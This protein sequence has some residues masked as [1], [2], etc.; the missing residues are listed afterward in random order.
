MILT[1]FTEYDAYAEAVRDVSVVMRLSRLQEPKWKLQNLVIGAVRLQ[2]GFE[3][4]G[5]IAEGATVDDG[6][7]FFHQ[8]LPVSI[9][10]QL[11]TKEQVFLVPPGGEF[12]LASH[13]SHEWLTVT[14]PTSLLL[15]SPLALEHVSRSSPSLLE[16]PPHVTRRFT[17]LVR[18]VLAAAEHRPQLLNRPVVLESIK[19]DLIRTAINLFTNRQLNASPHFARWRFQTKSAIELALS[20][21]DKALTIAELARQLGAP[22]RS[23]RTAFQKCYAMAPVELLRIYRLHQ[24]RYQ[25]LASCPDRNTVTEIAFGLGFWE[26]GRFA[27]AYRS[28]YGELPSETLRK[29][30][31]ISKIG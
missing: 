21:V 30:S 11:L 10:G 15:P 25:L 7:T 17:T 29:T 24:A 4:G 31:S 1:D 3:G 22:E 8:P 16:P 6:W 13:R 23:L 26:L 27:R 5:T 9:N 20:Q 19:S 12:C 18:R 14:I 2:Q 28:L